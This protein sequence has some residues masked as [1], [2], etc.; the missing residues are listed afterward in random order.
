MEGRKEETRQKTAAMLETTD[1]LHIIDTQFIP[2]L[3]AVGERYE[4]GELFLPQLIQAA[5][6][7]KCGFEVLKSTM[8]QGSMNKGTVLLAT[9]VGDIHDIGKNIAK[10]LLENYGYRVIDLGKDVPIDTVVSAALT[11]KVKLIGLSALMTTTVTG[12]KD[13]ITAL[14]KAGCTAEI[15]VGGAVLNEEYVKFVGADH[16]VKDARADVM[17]ANRIFGK[18]G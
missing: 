4:K 17:I 18:E 15:M 5:E 9:V 7:V 14:R 2:A 6:A 16:Y 13:T 3:D 8:P 10:M 12:M 11:H 1:A